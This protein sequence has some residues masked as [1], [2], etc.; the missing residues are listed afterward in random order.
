MSYHH[1][2]GN[3]SSKVP[4]VKLRPAQPQE[5]S[6]NHD[7]STRL[8]R[9]STLLT[10]HDSGFD[11][12]QDSQVFDIVPR[13]FKRVVLCATGISDKTT[14]FKQAIELGAQS[15]QDLTDRVTHLLAVEPGSAKYKCALDNGIPV[16]HPDWVTESHEIWLRGDDVDFDES[17]RRHRLPIFNGVVATLTGVTPITKRTEINKLLGENG[18]TYLKNL[19]RPVRVTHLLCGD[20]CLSPSSSEI[21]LQDKMKYALKFNQRGEANIKIIWEEWFWDSLLVGGRLDEA[22]YEVDFDGIKPRPQRK[23]KAPVNTQTQS[24]S[25]MA[26]PASSLAN[27]P[28]PLNPS[29]APL[30]QNLAQD[31][32]EQ[33][34]AK[35]VPG[36]TLQIWESL[37]KPRG[38]ELVKGK[39]IRSPSKSQSSS[40]LPHLPPESPLKG[41]EKVQEKPK[42]VGGLAG[43]RRTRSSAVFVGGGEGGIQAESTQRRLFGRTSTSAAL[44]GPSGSQRSSSSIFG[45]E[46]GLRDSSLDII[47]EGGMDVCTF[48][49]SSSSAATPDLPPAVTKNRIFDGK[50]LTALGEANCQSVQDA[51]ESHGG[52]WISDLSGEVAD[53][54]F[55][56]V[57][58]VSGSKLYKSEQNTSLKAK[59]RTE[60]WLERC[61]YE[62]RILCPVSTS[63][64]EDKPEE[65]RGVWM[66]L[67]ID[68]PVANAETL[69]V[70]CSGLDQSESY[71]VKRLLR[72]L[73]IILAPYFSR[74]TTHLLC[75]SK[76]G[77]KYEKAL[78]WGVTVVDMSWLNNV[79]R[80]GII[81]PFDRARSKQKSMDRKGKGQ[82]KLLDQNFQLN[83]AVLPLNNDLPP[84][85]QS[86]AEFEFG[87]PNGL[88]G[89]IVANEDEHANDIVEGHQDAALDS[90]PNLP[91]QSSSPLPIEAEAE[92]EVA[93]DPVPLF[94]VGPPQH[95]STSNLPQVEEPTPS[96]IAHEK[97]Y[98]EIPSSHSPSPMKPPSQTSFSSLFHNNENSNNVPV[99]SE[100]SNMLQESLT[101]LLGKRKAMEDEQVG[102]HGEEENLPHVKRLWQ[103]VLSENAE[104]EGAMDNPESNGLDT[105]GDGRGGKRARPLGR[106]KSGS[107][108]LLPFAKPDVQGLKAADG[109]T[110]IDHV[111][112]LTEAG[113]RVIYEDPYAKDEQARLLKLLAPEKQKSQLEVL[114][115]DDDSEV[116]VVDF[117][118][119]GESSRAPMRTVQ[120]QS[121]KAA[122]GER[123][124]ERP[125]PRMKKKAGTSRVA[126][127]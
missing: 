7:R 54:D 36:V 61:I 32:D 30:K 109:S 28:G 77:P 56:V 64:E 74:E 96:F 102:D 95:R 72:A 47:N 37:L 121:E 18:G 103:R 124:K 25:A 27:A 73:G 105:D 3:K 86:Q 16:M 39:L 10:S 84:P 21:Q 119:K 87:V 112:N 42:V 116:E 62:E 6:T 15:L 100:S 20:D 110:S 44:A 70:S 97:S 31:E 76:T 22:A 35:R 107:K 55:I 48:E 94:P 88:L 26:H 79:S 41:K 81:P 59:Y 8:K 93:S 85:P 23:T 13:P 5:K 17:V 40:Q 98:L 127:F 46:G 126:G 1:R 50:K 113:M 99:R 9:R 57:R 118:K 49:A 71:S 82:L 104:V 51:V 43:L 115:L 114:G 52:V 123:K 91:P 92:V 2:R 33:A 66:P 63:T 58:L 69:N 24:T 67:D 117:R 106:S 4:N 125:K 34:S 90:P 78:E 101:K 75:P 19:E 120:A 53:V 29:K 38:F 12:D 65:L 80:T 108:E 111:S 11:S 83:V 14:I 89:G 60:C 122:V 68:L 45:R